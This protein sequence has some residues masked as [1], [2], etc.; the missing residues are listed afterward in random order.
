MFETY[1]VKYA[2][3][4][5]DIHLRQQKNSFKLN[6]FKLSNLYF[7][8]TYE[9]D[10]LEL[11]EKIN[12]LDKVNNGN[13]Y[14]YSDHFYFTDFSIDNYEI[15]IK[16]S[17]IMKKQGGIEKVFEKKEAVEKTGKKYLFILDKDY[18]EFLKIYK[19]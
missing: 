13:R 16:S 5:K 19:L 2:L 14:S 4:D 17:W 11:C 12:I 10:F 15:E 1:G 9:Y 3:Q 7:Q 8:S 6:K 18:S